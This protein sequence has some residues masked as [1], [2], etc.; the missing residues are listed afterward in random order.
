MESNI[1]IVR[2]LNGED[3]IGNVTTMDTGIYNVEE[4]MTVG[5]EYRNKE[6]GLMMH[7]WLPVQLLKKNEI[8][9][10]NKDI[11]GIL[12]PNDEFC[13]YYLNTVE[14]IKDLLKAKNLVDSLDDEEVNDIMDAFEEMG[15]NGVTLHQDMFICSSN[16]DI[17]DNIVL[18]SVC[19][20]VFVV[21]I[22]KERNK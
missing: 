21:Y 14:K 16:R 9:I 6:A 7:H 18:S 12:D 4:P 19:Q 8:L 2:L 20:A 15:I 22:I 17:D 13:E 11:L 1:K 3:I 5:I 10:E